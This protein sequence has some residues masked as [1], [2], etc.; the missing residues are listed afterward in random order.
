MAEYELEFRVVGSGFDREYFAIRLDQTIHVVFRYYR[1]GLLCLI[2][3]DETKLRH[4]EGEEID[5][6]DTNEFGVAVYEGPKGALVKRPGR[7]VK[8]QWVRDLKT[9]STEEL[10][11]DDELEETRRE[12]GM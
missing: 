10:F 7:L 12:A 2:P 6:Y 11:D 5:G 9:W 8:P 4:L 1:P 3:I